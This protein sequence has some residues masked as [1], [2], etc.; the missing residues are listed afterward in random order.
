MNVFT[1]QTA[2]WD[3]HET[4]HHLPVCGLCSEEVHDLKGM[5][6][7]H[8]TQHAK[9]QMRCGYCKGLMRYRDITHNCC[10]TTRNKA[11][12]EREVFRIYRMKK[13]EDIES[14]RSMSTRIKG[15]KG[16]GTKWYCGICSQE[17]AKLADLTDHIKGEH[18]GFFY[19]VNFNISTFLK[20]CLLRGHL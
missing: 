7:H 3:A 4:E 5:R 19:Q 9:R 20:T 14:V 12:K 11:N 15:Y 17:F 8:Q 18:E 6:L 10:E 13:G 1:F 2:Q 16:H